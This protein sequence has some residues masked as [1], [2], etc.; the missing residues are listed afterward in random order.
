MQ[1]LT[2]ILAR[3]LDRR[4]ALDASFFWT[5]SWAFPSVFVFDVDCVSVAVVVG[6]LRK[7]RILFQVNFLCQTDC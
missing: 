6:K 5:P 1:F 3:Q 4:G 7:E 2:V